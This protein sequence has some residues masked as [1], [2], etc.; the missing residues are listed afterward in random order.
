ME[1]IM[2]SLKPVCK[3]I[4]LLSLFLIIGA[5]SRNNEPPKI[6]YRMDT[7]PPEVIFENGFE[8]WGD[9]T[10]LF[11]HVEGI[12]MGLTDGT[13]SAYVATTTNLDYALEFARAV[14]PNVFY[15]YE[16]RA[17]NNFYS[18]Y[19]SFNEY[20]NIESGYSAI[21]DNFESSNEY[22]AYRGIPNRQIIRATEYSMNGNSVTTIRSQE[23]K[24]Y[25]HEDTQANS[26]AAPDGFSPLDRDDEYAEIYH[27]A[28]ETYSNRDNRESYFF[29]KMMYCYNESKLYSAPYI[30]S[31]LPGKSYG[32]TEDNAYSGMATVTFEISDFQKMY[33]TINM[34]RVYYKLAS[35]GDTWKNAKFT[36]VKAFKELERYK[37]DLLLDT[38]GSIGKV[39][40]FTVVAV[41]YNGSIINSLAN[42]SK[43]NY[44]DD[45]DTTNDTYLI[46][47][48]YSSS[49]DGWYPPQKEYTSDFTCPEGQ[50]MIGRSHWGSEKENTYYRCTFFYVNGKL[51]VYSLQQSKTRYLI[52]ESVKSYFE[53]PENTFL[54]GREYNKEK[55]NSV[56]YTCA[57]FFYGTDVKR[58]VRYKVESNHNILIS[59]ELPENRH[60]FSCG[61]VF[62]KADSEHT[63]PPPQNLALYSVKFNGEFNKKVQYGC[64]KI[65][66]AEV[67]K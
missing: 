66:D 6:V 23:N 36:N 48:K 35:D 34:Y 60:Q 16:I 45:G 31:A 46:T 54:I 7:R 43:K 32:Q 8:N 10:S 19:E 50:V 57:K 1:K 22:V 27:C 28:N 9:E 55:N 56:Y 20:A 49:P 3:K 59:N 26:S 42:E 24:N 40:A 30:I 58:Y 29:E 13:G 41:D 67:D 4:L 2:L 18:I 5:S 21:R 61:S 17:S 15:I 52:D 51:A 64:A 14:R 44:P 37:V 47:S 53:C 11:E 39:W 65:M 63:M 38:I 62:L 33:P 25:H 12:S